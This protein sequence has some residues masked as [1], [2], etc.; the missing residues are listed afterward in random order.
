M[1]DYVDDY[2][3]EYKSA[4][5]GT[6]L[7]AYFVMLFCVGIPSFFLELAVGQ[8]SQCGPMTVWS[9]VPLLKGYIMSNAHPIFKYTLLYIGK[10]NQM[11]LI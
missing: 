4:Q 1:S 9:A 8:Y 2:V 3:S 6:F 10:I 5:T 7:I 11:T